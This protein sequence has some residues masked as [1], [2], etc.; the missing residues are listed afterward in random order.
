[1][2]LTTQKSYHHPPA[3]MN[4]WMRKWCRRRIWFQKSKRS[5]RTCLTTF[6]IRLATIVSKSY[7]RKA[8]NKASSLCCRSSSRSHLGLDSG[9]PKRM[10]RPARIVTTSMGMRT[11][12]M[13][14]W[15]AM[16]TTRRTTTLSSHLQRKRLPSVKEKL[17]LSI[18][19]MSSMKRCRTALM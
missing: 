6:L 7:R 2:I 12:T 3:K 15:T 19:R 17:S 10:S 8:Q 16:M 13:A 5:H 18:Q 1:M 11:M 14:R 9:R 4:T